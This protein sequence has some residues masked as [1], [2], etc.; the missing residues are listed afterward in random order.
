MHVFD[1]TCLLRVVISALAV[2]NLF[3]HLTIP[4]LFFPFFAKRFVCKRGFNRFGIKSLCLLCFGIAR[5]YG[6][7]IDIS[8]VSKSQSIIKSPL[9]Y[10]A[11]FY[12]FMHPPPPPL[13]APH[14]NG[15]RNNYSKLTDSNCNS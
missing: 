7:I 12:S 2:D 1:R 9:F 3:S 13:P 15:V 11:F 8:C 4:P 5:M 14:N 6:T 10:H